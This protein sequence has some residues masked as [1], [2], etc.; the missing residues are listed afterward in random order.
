MKL[1]PQGPEHLLK[2]FEFSNDPDQ[3]HQAA[4][5]EVKDLQAFTEHWQRNAANPENLLFAV[6]VDDQHVGSVGK[7]VMNG[8]AE[9]AY[10][11]GKPFTGRGLATEAVTQFLA[12]YPLRPLFAHVVV[13][14]LGSIK[15]LERNGFTLV[16]SFASFAPARGAEVTELEFRLN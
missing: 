11:I 2:M 16:D 10:W 3:I 1:V 12:A 8:D 14:N 13:D 15:V 7:W 5:A 4:F 6:F 9:L